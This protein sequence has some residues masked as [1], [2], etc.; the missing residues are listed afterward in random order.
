MFL[1]AIRLVVKYYDRG[2][3]HVN[4]AKLA[5]AHVFGNRAIVLP[6]FLGKRILAE[7]TPDHPQQHGNHYK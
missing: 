4:A 1:A 7:H 2:F 6:D 5:L 3:R